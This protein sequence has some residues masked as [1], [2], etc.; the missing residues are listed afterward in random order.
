[1]EFFNITSFAI[2]YW[3][4]VML[5]GSAWEE[6]RYRHSKLTGCISNQSELCSNDCKNKIH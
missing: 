5:V 1:M 2:G 4:T 3:L 6:L